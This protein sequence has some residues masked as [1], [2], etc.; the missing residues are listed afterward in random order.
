M[1]TPRPHWFV[2][3]AAALAV[4]A[5]SLGAQ[6]AGSKPRVIVL[7]FDGADHATVRELMDRGELPNLAALAK[8][9]SFDRLETTNPAESAVSWAT[10]GCGL[11][12]GQSNMFGFV[13]RRPGSYLPE[14]RFMK[15]AQKPFGDFYDP[16]G[17]SWATL[18]GIAG[19][20]LAAALV[21]SRALARPAVPALLVLL[22]AG[23][24]SVWAAQPGEPPPDTVPTLEPV[25]EGKPLWSRLD[26]AGVR[27]KGLLV[28]MSTPIEP[29]DHG[30]MTGGLGVPDVA[31]NAIGTFY[32]FSTSRDDIPE[33]DHRSTAS[34]GNVQFLAEENGSY[35]GHLPGPVD[36]ARRREITSR[37]KDV[38]EQLRRNPTAELR[39]ERA[40][41]K[42][43]SADGFATRLEVR[44]ARAG[45]GRVRVQIG[46]QSAEAAEGEWSDWLSVR[47]PLPW[48]LDAAALARFR[49]MT[50]GDEIRLFIPPLG[51]DPR[52][53]PRHLRAEHPEGFAKRVAEE[54]GLFDTTGWA[55]VT[56]PLKDVE[57]DEDVFLE[58]IKLLTADRAKA[59]YHELGK[60][61]YDFFFA[62]FGETDRVQHMMY[63][64]VDE[65]HPMYDA[66]VAAKYRSAITDAY[67]AMDRIVGEIA[68]RFVDDRTY[69]LVVSDHGFTS[70]RR[71]VDLNAWL[72]QEGYLV[73]KRGGNNPAELTRRLRRGDQ[74]HLRYMDPQKSRAFAL[75][76]GKIYLNLKGREANGIV[77]PED[78]DALCKEITDKLMAL[79]DPANDAAV[80]RRVWRDDELYH[81]PHAATDADLTV[82]FA[83]YYRISWVNTTGGFS[84]DV[85]ADND[86]KWSGD[87]AS[88]DPDVVPG[89]LFANRPLAT[90]Q[91]PAII[92]MAPT[93][94]ALFGAPLDG[95]DG[96]A[97]ALR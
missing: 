86:S 54:A 87:H 44:V 22:G 68:E 2:H 58:Q 12:P 6:D 43:E 51:Y 94:L 97:L 1:T 25:I 42:A 66:E 95:L 48:P 45:D 39:E 91:N 29:L 16:P 67:Q 34:L 76:L 75:G 96:R 89:I 93:I 40:R 4:T 47:F 56:N 78:R 37:L 9:G 17:W 73:A 69:L 32:I 20:G 80:V 83:E 84:A 49:V 27:V 50:A 26:N 18:L 59:V 74:R 38:T 60:D 79:R 10:F 13:S 31:G 5:A 36:E 14:L 52:E 63:R 24:V 15:L 35:V 19:A 30:Q 8:R 81:G 77:E 64:L 23:G 55:C 61:D 88:N 7:G 33:G 62:M 3:A 41:L 65:Q 92:D 21:L 28:P 11:N 46:D 70:F 53:T 90:G 85:I 71:Q 57:I 82:G 72:I